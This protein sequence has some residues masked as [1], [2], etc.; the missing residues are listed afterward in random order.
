MPVVR[1]IY[2]R[3]LIPQLGAIAAIAI[4]LWLANRAQPFS[5][6]IFVSSLVYLLFCRTMRFCFARQHRLG[7]KAYRARQFERAIGHYEL[8]YAGF[9]RHP[10][11]DRYRS[12][13]LGSASALSYRVI[14][15]CNIAFCYAQLDD[16]AKAVTYYETAL[17][18]DPECT[19]AQVSLRMLQSMKGGEMPPNHRT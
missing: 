5:T 12:L 15:L 13:L 6:I 18:E 11:V 7:I 4:A 9:C 3:A 17:R 1:Q 19:L 14:A 16:G 2:W 8:S 10:F